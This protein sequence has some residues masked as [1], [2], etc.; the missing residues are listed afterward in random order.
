MG[1]ERV[2]DNPGLETCTTVT[3]KD[4]R[5]K[6]RFKKTDAILLLNIFQ[7]NLE[8][9]VLMSHRYL[10]RQVWSSHERSVLEI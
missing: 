5:R 6:N 9:Q 1:K 7:M 3:Y 4:V 8:I 2:K 10:E